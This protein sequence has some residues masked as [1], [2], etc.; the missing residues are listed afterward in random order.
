MLYTGLSFGH[1]R[2]MIKLLS[3]TSNIVSLCEVWLEQFAERLLPP[4]C[5]QSTYLS[6]LLTGCKLSLPLAGQPSLFLHSSSTPASIG[7]RRGRLN[8]EASRA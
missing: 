7:I 6:L 8:F 4:V 5:T 1:T 2:P 3:L